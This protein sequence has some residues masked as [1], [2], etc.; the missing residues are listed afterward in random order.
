MTSLEEGSVTY[1]VAE[2]SNA[3]AWEALPGVVRAEA[4]RA[5]TNWLA[6]AVGGSTT[7]AMNAAVRGVLAIDP[8]GRVPVPGRRERVGLADA[9]LLGCLSSTSQTYDDTHFATTT[10]PTGPIASSLLAMAYALRVANRPVSGVQLLT[11]LVVG[12]EIECRTGCALAA[13]GAHSGWFMTGLS[14]GMGT[15]A[16]VGR[17][18]RLSNQQMVYAVGL[19]ATQACGLRA[20]HGSMAMTYVPGLAARNGLVAAHMAA[21]DFTCGAIALD[22]RNGLLEILT[23]STN[24]TLI[25]GDL[26]TRFEFLSNTYKPYPCGFVIHPALEACLYIVQH[27]NISFVDIERIDARVHPNALKLCWRKLPANEFEAQVSLFHWIASAFVRGAAGTAEGEMSCVSDVNV[28]ALQER[29]FAVAD[30]TLAD[31]QAAVSVQLR[32]GQS[33]SHVIRNS[34]GSVTNPLTEKQLIKKFNDLVVPILGE[35]RAKTL[36]ELCA[37]FPSTADAAQ[38]ADFATG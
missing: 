24:A 23:N 22:G 16:A 3:T 28:R 31:N 6:C 29:I 13:N 36:L 8:G 37:D 38:I 14:G 9:A 26:G 25:G 2:F 5:W 27:C 30:L 17:L 1:S 35:S 11:A 20:T 18:L 19:A 34:I 4:V 10:H 33:L 12:M 7:S 21:A 15:A 32:S